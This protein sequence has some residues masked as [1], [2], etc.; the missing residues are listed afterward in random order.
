VTRGIFFLFFSLPAAEELVWLFFRGRGEGQSL[1]SVSSAA[2]S[3]FLLRKRPRSLSRRWDGSSSSVVL[4]SPLVP[5]YSARRVPQ[6]FET[7]RRLQAVP[8]L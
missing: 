2:L 3:R 8:S 6:T 4:F 1:G 7:H 5:F